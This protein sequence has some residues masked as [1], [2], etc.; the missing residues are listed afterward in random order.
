MPVSACRSTTGWQSGLHVLFDGAGVSP[1]PDGALG[2]LLRIPNVGL[3]GAAFF[4]CLEFLLP[5]GVHGLGGELAG[6]AL[7]CAGR[8]ARVGGSSHIH[9]L[10]NGYGIQREVAGPQSR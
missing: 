4:K 1:L 3:T 7:N 9:Q 6:F 8:M 10:V 5:C 2:N